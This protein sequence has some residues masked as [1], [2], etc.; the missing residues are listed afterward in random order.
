MRDDLRRILVAGGLL[1]A[2]AAVVPAFA[3]NAPVKPA[4]ELPGSPALREELT[5][6]GKIYQSRGEVLPVEYVIDRSL[7]S[8]SISLLPGFDRSLAE[9]GPGDR[10]LDIGAGEGQ[11][12]L[13]YYGAR[14]DA[15]H[16]EGQDRRG[17]KAQAVAVS[18][19]DR[20][21]DEWHQTAG[22]LEPGKIKYLFGKPLRRYTAEELGRFNL[23]SDVYGGFSYTPNLSGFMEKVLSSLQLNGSFY[24]L[25]ID[26]HP[27][28]WI[29]NKPA[30]PRS[31]FQTEIIHADGSEMKVCAWLRRISCV[32]VTCEQEAK[33]DTPIERYQIRKTC[34]EVSVPALTPVYFRAG[35]P[36]ARQF[37][38]GASSAG[39]GSA[40]R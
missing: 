18:I 19:E 4:P 3:Q 2:I 31:G 7:I 16:R 28:N 32:Q 22:A 13:D 37:R 21:T 29:N 20:R 30:S 10:W 40:A 5:V 39:P 6:Q 23:A 27:E 38:I 12:V 26:V 33:W 35:T 15:M 24:T 9:L 1:A 36:P 11:A 34:D 8:Y 14:Y 17:S 25:L